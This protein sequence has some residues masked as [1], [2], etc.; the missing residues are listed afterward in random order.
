[1][2]RRRA[3]EAGI[4]T[5]IGCHTFRAPGI[6]S[7]LKNG[8]K[9]EIAQQMANHEDRKR[10]VTDPTTLIHIDEADR[11]GMNSLEQVRS[12]FD[13]SEIGIVLINSFEHSAVQ[14]EGSILQF[15]MDRSMGQAMQARCC[16]SR[17]PQGA[18]EV[19]NG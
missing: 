18:W 4:K 5:E 14:D 19:L 8:G 2:I 10:A 16:P 17:P 13:T 1:M 6:T 12:I 3:A 7:Y 11:L 15:A 9:L